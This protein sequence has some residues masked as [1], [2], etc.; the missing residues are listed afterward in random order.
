MLELLPHLNAALN[1]T[2]GALLFTGWR[3]IKARPR[4]V[5]RHR[6]CMLAAFAC[7]AL[8]LTS[9]LTRVTLGGTHVYPGDGWD[10]TFYIVLL[11][12]HVILAAAVPVLALRTLYLGLRRRDP[13][14]RRWA[15]ITF[16][17]WMYVSVTGVLVYWMLYHYAGIA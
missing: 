1:A 3:F 13:V 5:E 6:A 17:I 16:P 12:S 10:R 11:A 15:R 8:F 2:A 7:S 14:H 4:Q 9:Y